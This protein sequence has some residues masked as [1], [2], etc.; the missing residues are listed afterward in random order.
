LWAG[1]NINLLPWRET[2][3]KEKNIEFGVAVGIAALIAAAIGFAGFKYADDEVSFQ[4]SRND[5]LNQEIAQLQLE[6]K[7]IEKLEE[8]K[9]NLLSR[10][11]VVQDLQSLRPQVVHL[12]QEVAENL[13]DGVYLTSMNQQAQDQLVIEGRAESN[14][15]VSALMRRLDRSEFLRNPTLELI[16]ANKTEG[17]STFKMNLYQVVPKINEEDANG[18]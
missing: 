9:N 13:P 2:H 4:Q 12:F 6:L 8:T 1:T 5:R 17:F 11:E 14:A 7:E 16:E 3:R 15:R 10:M 18:L